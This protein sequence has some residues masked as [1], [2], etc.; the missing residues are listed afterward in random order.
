MPELC[1]FAGLIFF[2]LFYDNQH[3]S[4]AHVHVQ[5]GDYEASIGLDGTILAG[6]LPKRQLKIAVGWIALHEEE[7]KEAWDLAVQGKHFDSIEPMK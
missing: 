2:M 6:S 3:H 1:R 7:L 5:Y 4:L